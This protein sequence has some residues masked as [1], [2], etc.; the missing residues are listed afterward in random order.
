[1][2]IVA[3]FIA[4]PGWFIVYKMPDV[5]EASAK[6]LVD[7]NSLLPTLTKGLTATENV[8][9]EVEIV[10]RALLT[11]PNLEEVARQTDLDLRAETRQEQE[12]LITKLQ[13]LVRIKGG[14][15]KIFTI[16]FQDRSREKATEV[17]AALLNT[18]VESSLG[19]QGDDAA[20]TGRAIKSEIDDHERRLIEAESE[21]AEFKKKNLGY[22][23]DDGADYYTRLQAAMASV[24]ETQRQ[25]RQLRQR[26]DE[27]IAPV[28]GRSVDARV[29]GQFGTGPGEL[30]QGSEHQ[31]FART[32]GSS[33]G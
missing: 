12:D 25:I 30:L 19:A 8:L 6:V 27:D 20:M 9:D 21:L 33:A 13:K 15:D 22:M 24:E 1:M 2:V 26:R 17:V 16:S 14:R 29:V 5:Y 3:W 10:Y 4:I 32:I 28:A 11:R 7:T 18:F 31:R 23:P